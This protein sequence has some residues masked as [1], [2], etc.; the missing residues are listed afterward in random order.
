[1]TTDKLT[2]ADQL[3]ALSIQASQAARQA[4]E[5]LKNVE[6]QPVD[7][8]NVIGDSRFYEQLYRYAIVFPDGRLYSTYEVPA[9]SYRPPCYAQRPA[10]LRTARILPGAR[11]YDTQT[12][13]IIELDSDPA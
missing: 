11:V 12:R 5:L 4:R 3:K 13:T 2:L 9:M 8:D 10:A 6:P 7:H 1:M